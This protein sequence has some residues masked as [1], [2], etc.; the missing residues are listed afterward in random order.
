MLLFPR[1]HRHFYFIAILFNVAALPEHRPKIAGARRSIS[2][3]ETLNVNCT[4]SRSK[5]IANITFLLNGFSV[6]SI[7]SSKHGIR[8]CWKVPE[9]S[10]V[11]SIVYTGK[12][13]SYNLKSKWQ[14]THNERNVCHFSP[15]PFSISPLIGWSALR[16]SKD[17]RS[18]WRQ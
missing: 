16:N 2:I 9:D 1:F 18:G 8:S 17:N 6:S 3:G 4:S 13:Q 7:N 11:C 12:W 15:F 5:P 14:C 10:C